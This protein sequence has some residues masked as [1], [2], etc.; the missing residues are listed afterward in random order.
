[1]KWRY[2]HERNGNNKFRHTRIH[3]RRMVPAYH[4]QW[5]DPRGCAA[6]GERNTKGANE[7]KVFTEEFE[8]VLV[9]FIGIAVLVS[10]GLLIIGVVGG[11][12]QG[13]LF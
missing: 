8:D 11:I 10:I 1:M 3:Q 6:E 9:N 7:M 2:S 12:E 5:S 13:L 4:G